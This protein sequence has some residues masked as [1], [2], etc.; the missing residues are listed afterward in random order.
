MKVSMPILLVLLGLHPH[1]ADEAV[2]RDGD[3]G[4]LQGRWT[5]KAGTRREI[6]VVI[7]IK[8]RDVHAAIKTPQGLDFQV[9]GELKLDETTSP[10]SLDWKKFSGPDQ[11][12]LPDIAAVYKIEGDT[13]TVC[14]GGFLGSRPKEFKPGEG[15]LADVVVFHRLDPKDARPDPTTSA[16]PAPSSPSS[17][18]VI[19]DGKQPTASR[20]EYVRSSPR[21]PALP[22]VR[23]SWYDRRRQQ[24]ARRCPLPHQPRR[25][26]S[27]DGI[28]GR[29]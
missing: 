3:L 11:Q 17:R 5:A 12:P 15:V 24:R 22:Q 27:A 4:R 21:P 7:E 25:L 28:S 10:R 14:N 26:E 1:A 23:R 18:R 20:V 8:G 29:N 9:Q 2:S 13:F 19:S 6:H 16:S